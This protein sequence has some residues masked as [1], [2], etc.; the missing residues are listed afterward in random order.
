MVRSKDVTNERRVEIHVLKKEG[1]SVRYISQRLGIPKSTVQDT[2]IRYK[3]YGT[4][5]SLSKTGRPRKTTLRIDSK[6]LRIA[7]NSQQPN[8]VDIANEL[9]EMSLVDVCPNT[10]RNRLNKFGLHGRALL[11]KPLL[12]PRNVAA[13]ID[14]ANKYK[15]WTKDD[16]KRVI[17]SDETKICLHGSDGRRWTWR[18]PGEMLKPKDVKQTRKFDKSIMVWGCLNSTGT[19][20][21]CQIN[22]TMTSHKYVRILSEHLIPSANRLVGNNYIFQQDNDSKHTAKNTMEWFKSKNIEVLSCPAHSQDLNP[23]E[24]VWMYVKSEIRKANCVNIEQ[25][26]EKT[27]E[28]W[29]SIPNDYLMKLIDSMPDRIDQVIKNNGYWTKY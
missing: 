10:I 22:G 9:K 1:Y 27:E 3:K 18:K 7:N 11:K 12:L 29:K 23:I 6:I 19:G 14:F 24:N 2:I 5:K 20:S 21:I 28:I 8:A 16:W 4:Y 15:N 17:W 13:R 25:L 26:I